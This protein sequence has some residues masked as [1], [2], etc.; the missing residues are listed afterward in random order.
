MSRLLILFVTAGILTPAAPVWG[1]TFSVNPT[2]I[3]LSA[4][5]PSVLLTI[6]NESAEPVRLQMRSH[7]WLQSTTGEMQLGDTTD[8]I[9]FP[10]LVTLKPGEQRNIRVAHGTTVGATEKT[11]RVFVEELPGGANSPEG[12]AV[13][14]LTRMG[15]P[16]FLQPRRV[17][18]VA[19][20]REVGMTSGRLTFTLAN[21]GNSFFI[22]DSVRVRAFGAAGDPFDDQSM[23]GWYILAGGHRRFELSL[24]A[25]TCARVRSALVE[26]KVG[27]TLLKAPLTTPGGACPP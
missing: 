14:V 7:A 4:A 17:Q 13:R 15:I 6:R 18:A 3:V 2:R 23:S 26:V 25:A 1:A 24:A 22:P 12:A 21:D 10:T 9:V 16:V 27:D 20:L 11:Y 5:T 8:L 19:S